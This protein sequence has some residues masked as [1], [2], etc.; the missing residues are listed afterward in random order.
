MNKKFYQG[1]IWRNKWLSYKVPAHFCVMGNFKPSQRHKNPLIFPILR[2]TCCLISPPSVLKISS[3]LITFKPLWLFVKFLATVTVTGIAKKK[4]PQMFNENLSPNLF[5]SKWVNLEI[6]SLALINFCLPEFEVVLSY[7][8][9]LCFLFA[10]SLL[11]GIRRY[12]V[13]LLVEIR[14]EVLRRK[15]WV[16]GCNAVIWMNSTQTL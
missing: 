8:L 11:P 16:T 6:T 10:S 14:H 1:K 7:L 12:Q 15:G 4:T 2:S 5:L 9:V 3:R 13:C